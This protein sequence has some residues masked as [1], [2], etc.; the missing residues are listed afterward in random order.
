MNK[1]SLM[2]SGSLGV[3]AKSFL[4]DKVYSKTKINETIGLLENTVS[5]L[6]ENI[7]L[8]YKFFD[9]TFSE[10]ED[11]EL[12]ENFS[13]VKK[14]LDEI[15]NFMKKGLINLRELIEIDSRYDSKI[16]E[17]YNEAIKV[18]EDAGGGFI[19]ADQ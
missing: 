18:I 12:K 5:A 19:S 10:V 11:D 8:V 15:P 17:K 7:N 6:K 9:L 13:K 16:I 3:S 1:K 14:N 2:F 4:N